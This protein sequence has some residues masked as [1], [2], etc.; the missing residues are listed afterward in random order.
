MMTLQNI[1]LV[2]TATTTALIA[3]L[4]Y[5]W[6]CSVIPGLARLNSV[7]YIRAMQSFNLAIQNQLF[8]LCF[9]GTAI[10]LPVSTYM[11]FSHPVTIRFWLLL[12]ASIAYLLGVMAV[13][14]FGNIPLN[15]SLESFSL[16]LSNPELIAEQRNNFETSW[17]NL[18]TIRT[19]ASAL[20]I[21]LVIIACINPEE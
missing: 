10:L 17:N 7:E 1:I 3:G 16:T 8:F 12:T 4:F 14:I 20:S 13:T 11:Y 21:V 9:F 5:A 15:N 6:T 2:L 18:H 19:I